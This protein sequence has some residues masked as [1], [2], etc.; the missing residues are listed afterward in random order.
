MSGEK[1][2]LPTPLLMNN[3]QV[4]IQSK[5]SSHRREQNER[6]QQIESLM[7]YEVRSGHAIILSWQKY[8]TRAARESTADRENL[9]AS[10]TRLGFSI[11]IENNMTS[12]LVEEAKLMKSCK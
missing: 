3:V 11:E 2:T 10:L 5:Q 7:T 12:P 1:K 4:L 6:A 9:K 8:A